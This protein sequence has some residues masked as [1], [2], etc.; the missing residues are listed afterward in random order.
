MG[1]TP[2]YLP[3][4][5]RFDRINT[6]LV[7]AEPARQYFRISQWAPLTRGQVEDSSI[8]SSLYV[9]GA[10]QR[11]LLF[12]DQDEPH[13]YESAL[14]LQID[15]QTGAV[16]TCLEYQ[17]PPEAR[18]S[19]D[20]SNVF[21]S[22]TLDGHTLYA[23][24]STEVLIFDLPNFRQIGYLSLPAFN[25]LHHVAPAADGKLLIANTGL[26]MV[27]LC[28]PQGETLREWSV[29][30]ED[31]W[32]R[33][34]RT[35]D[36][37]KVDSTKPHKSHP[38]FVFEMDGEVWVTRFA[39]RDAI[40]LTNPE[41]SIVI[42]IQAPHDG[43]VFG[44]RIY[45]TTVDG[46]IVIADRRSLQVSQ[47]IDLAQLEARNTLLGWCR[48]LLP[49]DASRIWVGFTR[50]RKTLF[51]ENVLWVRSLFGEGAI[52]KPTH[53]ALFDLDNRRCLQEIDLEPH[54]M[55][56]VFS[57]FTAPAEMAEVQPVSVSGRALRH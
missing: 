38:N 55:N 56:I 11:K 37:R 3:D 14:I 39:Q 9:V 16:Q 44:D 1:V 33:F 29:A 32:S 48:G 8:M 30:A 2:G 6:C 31:P 28:T 34:S 35:M 45:F 52:G 50:V 40:C 7:E 42:G 10:R 25:D 17:T 18:A 47:V 36:Y 51:K 19:Q 23:C 54:G 43:V 15:P 4:C 46:K 20:S 41:K 57:I 5:F 12:K 49:L 21:K 27:M 22:G 13:L 26:D 53:I 24:T